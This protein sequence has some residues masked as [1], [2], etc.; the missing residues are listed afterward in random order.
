MKQNSNSYKYVAFGADT[1][2]ILNYRQK[3]E[4]KVL[5]SPDMQSLIMSMCAD[6]ILFWFN[7]FVYTYNPRL[8]IPHIPF[9][10]YSY[11]DEYI[12]ALVH[13]IENG[14]DFFTDKS[15]DMGVTWIVLAVFLWGWRFHGWELRVGSRTKDYVD[16]GGDMNSLFE[17]MRYMLER[18]PEW[19]LPHKFKNERGSKFNS[20]CK[21]INPVNKNAIIGEATSPHF[22][23][24]GRSKAIFYDEFAVWNCAEEAW[25]AGAD[26]TNCR[27]VVST[28][29]GRGNK[30][31]DIKYDENLDINRFSLH[32]TLHPLKDEKWYNEECKR[33]TA[34]EIAQELDI[35]YEASTSGRVYENF[36]EVPLGDGPEF[37]Y[38]ARMPLFCTW[39]FGEGGQDPNSIMWLQQ[40]LDTGNIRIID[41][42]S[43]SNLDI[44]YF[45]TVITGIL[46]SEFSYDAAALQ[47]IERRKH[48]KKATHIGDPYNG[49]K[50]TFVNN[51]TIKKELEKHG[52]YMNLDRGCNSVK[53]RIEKGARLFKRTRIHTRCK[54]AIDSFQN[55]R[56]PNRDRQSQ[57]TAPVRKPVHNE[58][59]HYRTGWEYFADFE[60]GYKKKRRKPRFYQKTSG[61]SGYR[62]GYKKLL[63]T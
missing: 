22:G 59:S 49:D 63:R 15:R 56:W 2:D 47:G 9:T 62:D 21:L 24:G 10:T 11:Q 61:S 53:E 18:L 36:H 57:S 46:D 19:M 12:L 39:D 31:A 41:N 14:E 16:K 27:V 60:D 6:D 30:F 42:Y 5:D 13:A 35:S 45:G 7:T 52:I 33:R 17:K 51:T 38:D 58:Y 54:G 8:S 48:W 28:P 25:K 26:T 3:V 44:N 40:D 4:N 23:R 32:W 50:V 29:A 55:S 37:D 43:R 1:K 20:F 34:E